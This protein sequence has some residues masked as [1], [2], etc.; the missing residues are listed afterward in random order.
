MQIK[1]AHQEHSADTQAFQVG[2][3][4][5]ARALRQEARWQLLFRSRLH[6]SMEM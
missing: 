1:Q 3:V 6:N 4:C 5:E 2:G